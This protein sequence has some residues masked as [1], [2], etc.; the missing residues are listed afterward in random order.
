MELALV[1]AIGLAVT[2]AI[3]MKRISVMPSDGR[4]YSG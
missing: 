1:G 4:G 3:R 2:G